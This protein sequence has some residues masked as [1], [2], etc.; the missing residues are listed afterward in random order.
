MTVKQEGK[1]SNFHKMAIFTGR[2]ILVIHTSVW[3]RLHSSKVVA[4][5]SKMVRKSSD[6]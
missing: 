6:R 4:I 3:Y 1:L 5:N 2:E